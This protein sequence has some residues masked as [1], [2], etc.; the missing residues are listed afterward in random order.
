MHG[1]IL[2]VKKW[3]PEIKY[4]EINIQED[5]VHMVMNC[6]PSFGIPNAV[7]V[8]KQNTGRELRK[9]FEYIR[10]RYHGR[11]G[12]WSTGYYVSTVGL[13]EKTI[14]KYVKYQGKEDLGQTKFAF[15]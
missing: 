8:I 2:E 12:M 4:E 1:Q 3:Y 7:Q 6:P 11:G 9:K 15:S 10:K 5:H 13:D 14:R